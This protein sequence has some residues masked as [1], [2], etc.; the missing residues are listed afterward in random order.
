MYPPV[1]EK[2]GNNE[3]LQYRTSVRATN[4]YEVVTKTKLQRQKLER[5]LEMDWIKKM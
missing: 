4:N 1:L 3:T 2:I 5:V